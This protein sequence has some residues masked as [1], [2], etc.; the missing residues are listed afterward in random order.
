MCKCI[1]K[2]Y[3]TV[4]SSKKNAKSI[5]DHIFQAKINSHGNM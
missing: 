3:K 2:K 1:K 4:N 5:I